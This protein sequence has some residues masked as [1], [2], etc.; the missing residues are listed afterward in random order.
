MHT[1]K[2]GLPA[3]EH[4]KIAQNSQKHS[5][6]WEKPASP[7]CKSLLYTWAIGT[8]TQQRA[9]ESTVSVQ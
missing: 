5:R 2:P 6:Y 8:T 4:E 7:E 9:L 3:Q 1:N